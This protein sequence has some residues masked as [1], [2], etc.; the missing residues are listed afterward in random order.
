MNLSEVFK[1][2]YLKN[3]EERKK[4][5]L[6]VLKETGVSLTEDEI[7]SIFDS[8]KALDKLSDK[9]IENATGYHGLPLGV[10]TNFKVND[11]EY[12]VIPMAVEESSV[13][14]AASHGAKLALGGGGFFATSSDP[15]MTGQ[16][17]IFHEG[18]KEQFINLYEANKNYIIDII[19]N[20]TESLEKRGGG[21]RRIEI[22]EIKEIDTFVIEFDLDT[23]DAMGAN[24]I[25]TVAE[26]IGNFIRTA[27]GFDVGLQ[28]LTNLCLG[29]MARSYCKIPVK[30]LG[31]STYGGLDVA[32]RIVKAYKFAY[33]DQKRATTHNKGVMN[34]ID[35]LVIATGND[36]RAVE[37]AAHSYAAISGRYL[38]LTKWFIS[39]CKNFL[40]GE[41]ELP[42]SLGTVGGMTKLH[43][44]CMAVLKVLGMPS[45]KELCEITASV[46]L[47]QN[48]TALKALAT[49]GIQKG[50]MALHQ[51]NL[52]LLKGKKV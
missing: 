8:V 27:L 30:S 26:K 52:D 51:K 12:L 16:V 48:L 39:D 3:Q 6:D 5:I 7:S 20:A 19:K 10:A 40:V 34:G 14:A 4:L 13:I 37:S 24:I 38:P 50:H 2:F 43:P 18:R 41:I 49:E 36:W 33:H 42:L 17:E 25:N 47:A 44:G 21:F 31:T 9:F 15:I 35:P 1:G 11:K 45:S 46:G 22:K 23:R 29:R 32:E 28:I